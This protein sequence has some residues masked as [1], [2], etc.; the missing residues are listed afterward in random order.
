MPEVSADTRALR[1]I[2]HPLR[3]RIIEELRSSSQ[4][5][6]PQD[7]AQALGEPGNVVRY[8]VSTLHRA[9]LLVAAEPPAGAAAHERWYTASPQIL[10]GARSDD[11]DA[12]T[13]AAFTDLMRTIHLR[14]ADALRAAE[15][16]GL[17]PTHHADGTVWL[18]EE[19]AARLGPRIGELAADLRAASARAA[20]T[21][22]ITGAPIRRYSYLLDL[23]PDSANGLPIEATGERTPHPARE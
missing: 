16:T 3:L 15:L 21:A 14:H 7:L 9:G 12:P 5:L 19:D 20:E 22:R 4:P 18:L 8:H 10:N 6:R 2:S 11:S 1:A 13:A 23:Y 17:T